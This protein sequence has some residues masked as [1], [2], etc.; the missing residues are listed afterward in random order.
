MTLDGRIDL[1][2]RTAE[3]LK[4][5]R[6]VARRFGVRSLG[7]FGSRTGGK[8]RPDSDIDLC[9]DFGLRTSADEELAF[10]EAVID[11]LGTDRVDVMNLDTAGPLALREIALHGQPIYEAESKAFVNRQ[12]AGLG[13]YMETARFRR[14]G[15]D[16][17][18][19]RRA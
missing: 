16:L 19:A 4:V 11:A 3:H 5:L 10:H 8:T 17:L 9:V 6:D 7:A 14:L 13:I 1:G 2:P 18:R 15:S 12:V